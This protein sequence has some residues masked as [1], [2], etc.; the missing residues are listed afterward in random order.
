MY[1]NNHM[2]SN[3]LSPDNYLYYCIGLAV[4]AA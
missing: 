2:C 4:S 1:A 3:N